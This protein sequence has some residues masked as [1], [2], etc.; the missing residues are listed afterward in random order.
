M[1]TAGGIMLQLSILALPP[2]RSPSKP[3]R[4][5]NREANRE[6]NREPSKAS[7]KA[8]VGV[9]GY[10]GLAGPR[11]IVGGNLRRRGYT[12][13]HATELP[14]EISDKKSHALRFVDLDFLQLY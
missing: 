9:S 13:C 11:P 12:A 2:N 10:D 6:P 7:S 3:N 4:E 5:A 14:P 8:H 1:C